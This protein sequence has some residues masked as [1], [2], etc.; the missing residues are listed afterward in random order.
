MRLIIIADRVRIQGGLWLDFDSR[1]W[2][3][4]EL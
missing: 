3:G 2:D 4:G 1:E